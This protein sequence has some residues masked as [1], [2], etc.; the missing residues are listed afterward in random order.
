MVGWW[1]PGAALHEAS[2]PAWVEGWKNMVTRTIAP[3]GGATIT[4]PAGTR[5]FFIRDDSGDAVVEVIIHSP[6]AREALVAGHLTELED[7]IR[8]SRDK[9]HSPPLPLP[10]RP[11]L[12]AL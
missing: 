6:A 10:Q 1:P 5:R 8:A 12:S 4:I 3:A 9:E 7:E 11:H 2:S